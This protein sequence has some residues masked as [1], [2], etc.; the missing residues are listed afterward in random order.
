MPDT[1]P[2]DL[3]PLC[4]VL[5]KE[6]VLSSN[7]GSLPLPNCLVACLMCSTLALHVHN[8]EGD[9]HDSPTID[10]F[11]DVLY[12]LSLNGALL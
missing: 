1:R 2:S 12:Y 4:N 7:L 10:Y 11:Y 3:S 5:R 8:H 9:R 6:K